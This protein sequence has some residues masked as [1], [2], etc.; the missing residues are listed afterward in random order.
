MR[1]R[2][3]A[4]VLIACLVAFAGPAWS[5]SRGGGHTGSGH[6]SG[7]GHPGSGGHGGSGG[8]SHGN[9]HP[10]H[11]PH[12]G[13]HYGWYGPYGWGGFYPGF[14]M[15]WDAYWGWGWGWPYGYYGR[16]GYYGYPG[17]GTYPDSD[18]DVSLVPPDTGTTDEEAGE[19]PAPV[20]QATSAPFSG[21]SP[22]DLEV[23]PKSA[24]VY[25]NGVLVGSIEE[26]DGHP[27]FLY[28]DPGQ[29]TFDLRQPGY[30]SKSLTLHVGGENKVV[31]S[32][33]LHLDPT[34]GTEPANPPSPGLPYGRRF[35]PSFG[36]ATS[37][38]GPLPGHGGTIQ[39]AAAGSGV[40]ALELRVSPPG[41]AVYVDGVLLGTGENL[42]RLP[43][44]IAVSPGPHRID[45][46]AP[47]H[48]GKTIQVNAEAG[49]TQELGIA[50]E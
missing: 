2:V 9:P 8:H 13:G 14:P 41:A 10:G 27:D 1:S 16:Y 37:Q 34:S 39:P 20:S 48:T 7:G 23:S 36:P 26:F 29:Y 32:L 6:S 4:A 12:G 50:L 46:V 22:V 18:S 19:S 25:L 42:A 24:L 31:L 11:P 17:Y 44:G 43:Q 33:D 15:W 3:V 30:R 40:T 28:L 49:M 5:Q 47:G 35:G 21:P 45:V 38:P